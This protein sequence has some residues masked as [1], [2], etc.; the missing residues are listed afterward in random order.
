MSD[1]GAGTVAW[2]FPGQGS[3]YVG[4]GLSLARQQPG[5]ATVFDGADEMLGFP[6][7]ELIFHGPDEELQQTENQQPAIVATSAAYLVA[8]RDRGLLPE[9]AAVAGHSLGEYSA[10]V[11]VDSLDLNDALTLVRRRGD[12]MQQHGA[13]A[14]AAIIGLE[15]D[16]V[17]DLAAEAGAEVANFNAPGQTT[18]SGRRE[19]VATAMALAKERGARRV[20]QLPVSAAFHS[21]LM[22]PVVDGLRQLIEETAFREATVPLVTNVDATPI[23]HPD[24][25]R[26]EL[27]DQI[28][29]SVR[30]IDVVERLHRD[31]VHTF[32]EV[33]PGKVLSG[34]IGRIARGAQ[35]V[36]A[37]DLLTQETEHTP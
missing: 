14:M 15:P 6:L 16:A 17:A 4:M 23:Q 3:Q 30:W 25:L 19:T 26:R 32:I 10:L 24:D 12:L 9:P 36:A 35:T 8:L 31:G 34:L 13:G 5:A 18:V 28:C 20:V 22:E 27:L 1:G 21:S 29:A 7:S 11:A 2:V 33:G 37:E